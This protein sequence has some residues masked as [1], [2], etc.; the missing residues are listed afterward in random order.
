MLS[1]SLTWQ[2]AQE[3][4]VIWLWHMFADLAWEDE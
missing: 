1:T 4:L 3:Y 2:L